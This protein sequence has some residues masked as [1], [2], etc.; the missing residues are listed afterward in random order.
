VAVPSGSESLM[1]DASTSLHML[2]A[3]GNYGSSIEYHG[4]SDEEAFITPDKIDFVPA[5][6]SIIVDVYI[7]IM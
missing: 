3:H 1:H 4:G 7:L 5:N 6:V 2:Y